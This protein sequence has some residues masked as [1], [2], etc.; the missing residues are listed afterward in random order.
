M[1]AFVIILVTNS[2]TLV[3]TLTSAIKRPSAS[4]IFIAVV[5]LCACLSSLYQAVTGGGTFITAVFTVIFKL[6]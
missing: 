2:V 1:S 6:H 5:A 3:F 4:Y